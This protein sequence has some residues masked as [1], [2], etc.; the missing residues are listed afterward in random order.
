MDDYDGQGRKGREEYGGGRREEISTG[1]EVSIL[2]GELHLLHPHLLPSSSSSSSYIYIYKSTGH[3]I[4][5][6]CFLF[7]LLCTLYSCTVN[8]HLLPCS[9][10]YNPQHVQGTLC[11]AIA[12]KHSKMVLL[13]N[14]HFTALWYITL[15]AYSVYIVYNAILGCF[16]NVFKCYLQN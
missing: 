14:F 4:V 1:E 8:T 3:C 12:A 9:T 16:I 7:T 10:T 2:P 13:L 5:Y 15:V 11:S 6:N